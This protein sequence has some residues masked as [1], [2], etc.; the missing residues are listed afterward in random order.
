ML[1]KYWKTTI[2]NWL[3]EQIQ[4]SNKKVSFVEIKIKNMQ[5]E[6]R[7]EKEDCQIRANLETCTTEIKEYLK[8]VY[9]FFYGLLRNKTMNQIVMVFILLKLNQMN[10]MKPF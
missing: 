7:K 9:L 10:I 8:N 1:T 3:C 2:N 5:Y 6:S 4:D